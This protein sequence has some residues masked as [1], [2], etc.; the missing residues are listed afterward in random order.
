MDELQQRI[1]SVLNDPQQMKELLALA[2]SLGAELPEELQE[3]A[4]KP[5]TESPQE[6]MKGLGTLMSQPL[7]ALL[8]SA[9]K[10]EQKQEALL[11]ALRPFLKPNRR[12]KLDRAIR[13]ARLSQL[14]GRALKSRNENDLP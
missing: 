13:A 9:G 8:Q 4:A 12:E 3:S 1:E 6:P 11:N 7:G 2:R 5:E 14:A 10:L